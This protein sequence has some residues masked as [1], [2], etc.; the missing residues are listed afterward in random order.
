MAV[1]TPLQ[2]AAAVALAV[3]P[4][5]GVLTVTDAEVLLAVAHTP[6]V[7]DAR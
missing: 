4:T 1:L 6:L 3:P 7:T 5:F 2:I